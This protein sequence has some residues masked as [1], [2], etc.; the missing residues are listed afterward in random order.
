MLYS[1]KLA[2][3]QAGVAIAFASLCAGAFALQ[4]RQ[5]EAAPA[6]TLVMS[7][8]DIY[9]QVGESVAI[10]LIISGGQD[11]H[12]LHL[13]L[14]YDAAVVQVIDANAQQAGVQIL[15]GPFPSSVGEGTVL[16]NSVTNGVITYQYLL[17]N[18]ETDS[19]TGTV[20]TVQFVAIANGSAN[21]TWQTTQLVD[22]DGLVVS[23]S[24]GVAS[25][26]VGGVP[27]TPAP[28][29]TATPVE[30]A[31]ETPTVPVATPEASMTPEATASVTASPT[32]T[33][34]TASS[35]T[36]T[37]IAKT[38][39]AT[40]TAKVTVIENSNTGQPPRSGV[41]PAQSNRAEGLP[42]AGSATG[43]I[44]WWRWIF[45]LGA[46]MFGVA[47]WFFTLAVYN[48]SKE[49]VLVDRFDKRRRRK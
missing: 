29:S 39:A 22:E 2:L 4:P 43:S 14:G 33:P 19:G 15:R 16:Q 45:F 37:P 44:A 21:F 5:A 34:T 48:N 25:L 35:P 3:Q 9:L 6:G 46:L 1:M 30:A 10:T 47:G 31:T 40:A 17:P 36:L 20:A 49:V 27:P 11:I 18:N 38:A 32:S 26:Q 23:A 41:D 28:T 13:A 8:S 42:S 12:G 7:P 24:G